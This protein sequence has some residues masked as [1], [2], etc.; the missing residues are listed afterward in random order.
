MEWY[1]KYLRNKRKTAEPDLRKPRDIVNSRDWDHFWWEYLHYDEFAQT[2][3]LPFFVPLKR[4]E[5]KSPLAL[6]QV[7]CLLFGQSRRGHFA[8]PSHQDFMVTCCGEKG[9]LLEAAGRWVTTELFRWRQ[10]VANILL[11]GG[12]TGAHFI[13]YIDATLFFCMYQIYFENTLR[14][15]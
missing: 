2:L 4:V 15:Q 6:I 10:C 14:K 12:L 1:E 11:L 7:L 5:W 8:W 13:T 9:G 3:F